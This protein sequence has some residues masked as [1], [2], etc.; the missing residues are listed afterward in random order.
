M[1][2]VR[3]LIV[4][5][6]LLAVAVPARAWVPGDQR[7]CPARGS[8][9]D[10]DYGFEITVPVGL[11][12]CP[13]SP[14]GMSDHGVM[15]PVAKGGGAIEAYAAYNVLF[16]QTP[17]EAADGIIKWAAMGAV[18]GSVTVRSRVRG[19]LGGLPAIRLVVQYERARDH[20]L[21]TEDATVALRATKSQATSG[22]PDL[23]YIVDLDTPATEYRAE[24]AP[25][26][27]VLHSWKQQPAS[28]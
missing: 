19:V 16:W 26:E 10:S 5:G 3:V 14:V 22:A 8:Y 1:P 15:I 24:R 21:W 11:H 25:L 12:G 17:N 20:L 4:F 9:K 23:L 13:N 27:A 7:T 2:L 18:P 28:G 6:L